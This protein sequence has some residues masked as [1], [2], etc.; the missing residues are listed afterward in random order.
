MAKSNGKPRLA[1]QRTHKSP[2][3]LAARHRAIVRG[4]EADL[5]ALRSQIVT[6][7]NEGADGIELNHMLTQFEASATELVTARANLRRYENLTADV[8]PA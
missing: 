7:S 5:A 6:A 2:E 4:L 8:V 3:Q 1:P